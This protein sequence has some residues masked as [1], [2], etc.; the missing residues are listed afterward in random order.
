MMLRRRQSMDQRAV[1]GE[2]QHASRV[3]VEPADRLHAANAQRRGQQAQHARMMARVARAFIARRLVQHDQC[4][5]VIRPRTALHA[6]QELVSVDFG[7]GVVEHA[8]GDLDEAVSDQRIALTARTEALGVQH[9]SE[10]HAVPQAEISARDRAAGV[11]CSVHVPRGR[12]VAGASSFTSLRTT[13]HRP[14]RETPRRSTVANS[15]R[16]PP[17]A[18]GGRRSEVKEEGRAQLAPRDMSVVGHPLALAR[19][20]LRGLLSLLTQ[21]TPT[22]PP[23]LEELPLQ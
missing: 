14:D 9:L 4:L 10:P 12:P 5:L 15:P 7:I 3:F 13:P 18:A 20:G 2:Q 17:R 11:L 21:A 22:A 19:A 1:V 8:P 23:R 6:E 16:L